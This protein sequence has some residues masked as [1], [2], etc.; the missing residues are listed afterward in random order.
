MINNNCICELFSCWSSSESGLITIVCHWNAARMRIVFACEIQAQ[1]FNQFQRLFVFIIFAF[2]KKV[3][4]VP[5]TVPCH[6]KNH[7]SVSLKWDKWPLFVDITMRHCS[8]QWNKSHTKNSWFSYFRS[9]FEVRVARVAMYWVSS[10][11]NCQRQRQ[12][13]N[14]IDAPT[15]KFFFYRNA[16]IVHKK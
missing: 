4:R 6:K 9:D 15:I 5:R 11:F 12:H 3:I 10:A 14:E 7:C 16:K 1:A 2:W 13:D 8:H